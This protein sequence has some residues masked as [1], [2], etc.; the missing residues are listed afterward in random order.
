MTWILILSLIGSMDSGQ[1]IK[2]IGPFETERHCVVAQTKWLDALQ[3]IQD[4]SKFRKPS[5]IAICAQIK[6]EN[7]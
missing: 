5:G 1:Q 3:K 6:R 2:Q 4:A 7:K